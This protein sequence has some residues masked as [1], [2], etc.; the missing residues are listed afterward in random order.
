MLRIF[1][2]AGVIEIAGCGTQTK[3]S[4]PPFG[5]EQREFHELTLAHET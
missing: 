3:R 4:K 2:E 5:S 1:H